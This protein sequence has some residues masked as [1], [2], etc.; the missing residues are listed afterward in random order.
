[1]GPSQR[2]P[3][4]VA[5]AIRCAGLGVRETWVLLEISWRFRKHEGTTKTMIKTPRNVIYGFKVLLQC[6]FANL[7]LPE[8]ASRRGCN[9]GPYRLG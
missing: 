8:V 3:K 4:E 5:R 6:D 9:L 1:M 2:T 7:K